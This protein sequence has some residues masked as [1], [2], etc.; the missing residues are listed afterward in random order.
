MIV[1]GL[2]LV[3][4]LPFLDA[5]Y[6]AIRDAWRVAS[7]A[8]LIATTHDYWASR[9]P[10][11]PVQEVSSAFIWWGGPLALNL[12][13]AVIS[14]LGIAFFALSARRLGYADWPLATAAL[15]FTPQIYINSTSTIDYLWALSFTLAGLFFA[16]RGESIWTGLFLGLAIGS[17]VTSAAMLL[18]LSIIVA[19]Q[20][21]RGVLRRLCELWLV[22]GAVGALLFLPAFERYGWDILTFAEIGERQPYE[23]IRRGSVEVWGIF[24][25]FGICAAV[26][27]QIIRSLR[28]HRSWTLPA[29]R[30]YAYIWLLA[31]AL[32]VIA[33][34]RLPHLPA[35]L[36]PAIPFTLLFLHEVL[37]HRAFA[38]AC[39]A[40][41]VSPFI[42]VGPSGLRAGAIFDDRTRRT[43]LQESARRFVAAGNELHGENIVVAG[44]WFAPV[45]VYVLEHP[46][47]STRYVYLLTATEA[48]RHRSQGKRLYYLPGQRQLNLERHGYDLR[49]YGARPLG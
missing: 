17:R 24:G 36:I 8:R 25:A 48:G 47:K 3:T 23:I 28:S 32:Y 34:V 14:S 6:G 29:P 22:A 11:H 1:T 13:T 46:D 49:E 27:F 43:A 9:F 5:G 15:A 16:L 31:V 12:A 41:I 42:G 26:G 4:R 45:S 18:P 21:Q 20:S 2:T 37:G 33:Y 30:G 40:L 39:A 44:H 10:P 19:R 35:Y 7:A 38:L